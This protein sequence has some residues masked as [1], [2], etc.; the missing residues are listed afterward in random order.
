[1]AKND[2]WYLAD[3]ARKILSYDVN[4]TY[5]D[6]VL[7]GNYP[8]DS[9]FRHAIHKACMPQSDDTPFMLTLRILLFYLL[10]KKAREF[11]PTYFA[12]P[13]DSYHESVRFKPQLQLLFYESRYSAVNNERRPLKTQVSL[14]LMDVTPTALTEEDISALVSAIVSAFIDPDIFVYN[15][16]ALALTYNDKALGY[17]LKLYVD[18]K[19]TGL[20]LLDKVLSIQGHTRDDSLIKWHSF[21]QAPSQAVETITILGETY[22]KPV[23]FAQAPMELVRVEL[24]LWGALRSR[25]LVCRSDYL[26]KKA[27]FIF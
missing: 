3:V 6:V 23:R 20:A 2:Y 12:I 27:D 19:E 9:N 22:N 5:G 10:C 18:T 4:Q 1:M 14:R 7:D 15:K 16:G 24:N 8:D 25:L 11:H 17:Q 26:D 13:E 21:E